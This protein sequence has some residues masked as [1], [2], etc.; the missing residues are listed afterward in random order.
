MKPMGLVDPR[1]GHRPYAVV[2]LRQENLRADSYNLVGFQNH[3][4]FAEQ[5]RIMRLIPSLEKAE[6]VR[7]GQI[8][9]NTYINSPA[10]LTATLQLRLN[11]NVLFAG[12]I[13]GVE[14]YVESIDALEVGLAGLELGVGRA[15]KEDR[16]DPSAGIVIQAQVGAKVRAGD[17]LAVVHAR[18]EELVQK[19]IP[20]LQA[21]WRLSEHEVKRPPHV[22]ARVDKD[23][24]SGAG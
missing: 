22:L 9:R 21:A 17:T 6:F 16:V 7:F 24:V 18:S 2:Q 3:L 14:G 20:R 13:S 10:L 11:P 19:V 4:R 5:A 8:H 23:G 12:Q 15:R 1:T